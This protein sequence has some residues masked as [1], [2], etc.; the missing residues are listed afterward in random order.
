[1]YSPQ[2]GATPEMVERLD[3]GLTNLAEVIHR[4]LGVDVEPVPG[5]GAAG[6]LGAGIVAF[7]KG[8]LVPGAELVIRFS[9][10]DDALVDADLALT[11][12]GRIDRSTRYGKVPTAVARL[13][14]ARAIPVIAF[15]GSLASDAACLHEEGITAMI[16]ICPGPMTLEEALRSTEANLIR[17]VSEALSLWKA[18]G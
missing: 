14:K 16:P 7:L 11:G 4:D 5:A 8:K 18:G 6:G 10:L 1:V 2:K 13:C 3:R 9:G 12:E 15:G 17:C